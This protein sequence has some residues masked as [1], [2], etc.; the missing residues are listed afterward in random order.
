MPMRGFARK[1]FCKPTYVKRTATQESFLKLHCDNCEQDHSQPRSRVIYEAMRKRFGELTL[2]P[3]TRRPI[4]MSK[5]GIF[6]LL[7]ARYTA[8][9]AAAVEVAVATGIAAA[10]RAQGPAEGSDGDESDEGQ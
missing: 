2:D 8:R 6:I 10:D 7:K 4:L 3:D 9:K 5:T 1:R